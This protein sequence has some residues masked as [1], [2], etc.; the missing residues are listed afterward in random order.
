MKIDVRNI[1]FHPGHDDSHSYTAF[2]YINDQKAFS[3]FNDGWGASDIY[4]KVPGYTGPGVLEVDAW[5]AANTPKHDVCGTVMD[6]CLEFVVGDFLNAASLEKERKSVKRKYDNM[7]AKQ[8]CGL[9]E[10]KFY[11]W[12]KKHAVNDKN[13]AQLRSMG[14]VVLNGATETPLSTGPTANILYEEG[15]CAY[16][17]DLFGPARE[18][19]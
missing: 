2:I 5:L 18:V 7:L 3:A 16:S 6:N 12:P 10:G 1:K 17:P 11:A 4:D 14:Y 19:A 8:L 13:K 15:L 9:K